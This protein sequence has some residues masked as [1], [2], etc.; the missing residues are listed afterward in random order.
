[1]LNKAATFYR[2]NRVKRCFQSFFDSRI[3]YALTMALT[4]WAVLLAFNFRDVHFRMTALSTCYNSTQIVPHCFDE[5]IC[6]NQTQLV[7]CYQSYDSVYTAHDARGYRFKEH[8]AV[9]L[10]IMY[11]CL[12]AYFMLECILRFISWPR[13]DPIYDLAIII[14]D[15]FCSFPAV[16]DGEKYTYFGIV[17]PIRIGFLI[18]DLDVLRPT[19][20]RKRVI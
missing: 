1:M 17:L 4:I 13:F 14:A 7:K 8:R 18:A 19:G 9:E 20:K 2:K 3:Y 16:T 15:S 6:Y 10:S 12:L 11:Y 5:P